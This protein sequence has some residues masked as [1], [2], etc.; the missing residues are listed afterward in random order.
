MSANSS[1]IVQVSIPILLWLGECN[2][3]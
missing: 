3:D 2:S 1:P